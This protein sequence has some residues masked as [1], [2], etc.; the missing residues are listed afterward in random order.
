[1]YIPIFLLPNCLPLTAV[2]AAQS[3]PNWICLHIEGEVCKQLLW[4]YLGVAGDQ[5][6]V[7][8]CPSLRILGEECDVAVRY[9]STNKLINQKNYCMMPQLQLPDG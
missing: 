5:E 2:L 9:F 7:K 1:M 8:D 3:Y 6:I 4:T